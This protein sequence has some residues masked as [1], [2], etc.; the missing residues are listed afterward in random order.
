MVS[1]T[2]GSVFDGRWNGKLNLGCVPMFRTCRRASFSP[3]V[4]GRWDKLTWE[5]PFRESWPSFSLESFDTSGK[6]ETIFFLGHFV[7]WIRIEIYSLIQF[8]ICICKFHDV[9]DLG[10]VRRTGKTPMSSVS[11]R[12]PVTKFCINCFLTLTHFQSEFTVNNEREKYESF[13]CWD[14]FLRKLNHIRFDK[15]RMRNK[16]LKSLKIERAIKQ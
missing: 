7:K 11:T 3:I 6:K 16:N 9:P 8:T 12:S 4:A 2:N 5:R 14:I 15:I 13:E 1:S 10:L